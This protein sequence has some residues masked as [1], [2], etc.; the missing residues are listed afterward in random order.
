MTPHAPKSGRTMVATVYDVISEIRLHGSIDDACLVD[1]G[2]LADPG[3]VNGV[4]KGRPASRG[5]V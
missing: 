4:G 3:L 5:R 1:S 2:G